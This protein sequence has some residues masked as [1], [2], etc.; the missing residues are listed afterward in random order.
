MS[1]RTKT[2]IGIAIIEIFL[3]SILV[4]RNVVNLQD[5]A[6][7]DIES[8]A[9]TVATLFASISKDAL[10]SFDVAS[11]QDYVKE[12]VVNEGVEYARVRTGEKTLAEYGRAET[13]N[14]VFVKD[15]SLDQVDD[16][17][18]DSTVDISE[19]NRI[20]GRVEIGI[21]T[22]ESTAMIAKAQNRALSIAV[23]GLTL[24]ALFSYIL[25]TYLTMKLRKIQYAA[26][27]IS[28]GDFSVS[29][30]D[31]GRDELGQTA[32]AINS[33]S[34]NLDESILALTKEKRALTKEKEKSEAANKAK[35]LFLAN[36]S[37]EI[38]TPLNAIIALSSLLSRQRL[39]SSIGDKIEKIQISSES[40]LAQVNDI[41][42]ISKIEAS[43]FTLD[44][45]AFNLQELIHKV[46][47]MARTPAASQG[48]D[49]ICE[50]D[51]ILN[52][53]VELDQGRLRQVLTNLVSNAIKFTQRGFVELSVTAE[54][55]GNYYQV[56]FTVRDTGIG[57]S[58][59][60]QSELFKPF[61]QADISTT[62][63]FGGTGLGLSISQ[64]IVQRM[65]SRIELSS[66]EGLGSKFSFTLDIEIDQDV[67]TPTNPKL[68]DEQKTQLAHISE[69]VDTP[70]EVSDL[71][72]DE[73][74]SL[75]NIEEQEAQEDKCKILLVE[76]NEMNRQVM[77]AL[78]ET[79]G[80]QM[81]IAEDGNIGVERFQA[82][83]PYDIVLMDLQ[84]PN[85]DG[86]EAAT[87]IRKFEKDHHL[88]ST[89]II[90]MTANALEKEKKRSQEVGM[91]D[92]LTKPV[93]VDSVEHILKKWCSDHETRSEPKKV[94]DT[95]QT[96]DQSVLESLKSLN[97][98]RSPNF[99]QNQ[100]TGFLNTKDRIFGEIDQA[101]KNN[102]TSELAGLVH[103]FK[104]SCGIVG[105]KG[106]WALCKDLEQLA[107][108]N[109]SLQD[110][111]ACFE[112]MAT[113]AE[114]V[115]EILKG[116]L[117][118]AEYLT[119]N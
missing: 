17:I 64:E 118:E 15:L 44:S 21:S 119:A 18:F 25:G 26:Q 14:K 48:I 13:L 9:E 94:V 62:R 86:F 35:S 88:N 30:D 37:H 99:Y 110:C 65:G 115:Q 29:L 95:S 53:Q 66:D 63:Q 83:G 68:K 36:M 54:A 23:L 43:E 60:R 77:T 59:E 7:K 40:L 27:K 46:A 117:I 98:P 87:S 19:S 85:M 79:L 97:S 116:E 57:I 49:F 22:T 16:G 92:Y 112:L 5:Q 11:L 1:F 104:T 50:V 12:I 24:S 89:P 6:A 78:M 42:D 34:K 73:S 20:F 93:T 67:T 75:P 28:D 69:T 76:D 61:V 91:N 4:G 114:S 10:I 82:N 80:Y 100:L 56:K 2:I 47:T 72:N 81:E 71:K 108:D 74:Q 39:E 84:M 113:E 58:K 96:I 41:L 8:R 70:S 45:S 55:K 51:P 109:P 103:Y 102:N 31:Q 105:A 106:L 33:M 90:T 111:I 107:S 101:I 32:K 38:R 3:V 52:G